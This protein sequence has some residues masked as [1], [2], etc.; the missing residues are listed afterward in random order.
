M[1]SDFKELLNLFAQ[2][3]IRY[4]VVGGYAVM[5]YTEPMYT[6]DLD[7]WTDPQPENA[8]RTYRALAQFGAPLAGVTAQDFKD[9]ATIYQL[10]VAPVRID[11]LKSVPG[12]EFE[13]AWSNRVEG[14][15]WDESVFFVSLEDLIISK[16]TANRPEDRV[17][18]KRLTRKPKRR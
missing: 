1:N 15:L 12:L 11:I 13:S 14:N 7:L 8:E 6:K 3:H 2:H 10:G 9:P 5:K 17:A 18:V 16:R 4:L